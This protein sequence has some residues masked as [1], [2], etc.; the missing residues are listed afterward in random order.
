MHLKQTFLAIAVSLYFV[1]AGSC[2]FSQEQPDCISTLPDDLLCNILEYLPIRDALSACKT[3]S[4]AAI[5]IEEAPLIRFQNVWNSAPSHVFYQILNGIQQFSSATYNPSRLWLKQKLL[6]TLIVPPQRLF[7]DIT[8]R[9]AMKD[10]GFVTETSS[11]NGWDVSL[12]ASDGNSLSV[13]WELVYR[14]SLFGFGAG[15]FHQACD[16]E[17]KYVVVVRAEN[18]RI[19]V[20]YNEDGFQS[21]FSITPNLNGFI[22]SINEDGTCGAQFDRNGG[23]FG[24]F[25]NPRYGPV[26]GYF[27]LGILPERGSRSWLG[28]SYG[29][30]PE[31]NTKT[32]FGQEFFEASNYEVFKVVVTEN[33]SSEKDNE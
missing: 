20:A 26:I 6:Q 25:N 9:I 29:E 28:N 21:D 11:Q 10:R 30:R 27:D 13:T 33:A 8:K 14:A 23:E 24:I 22:V 19:A 1:Y 31:A 16:G 4:G 2:Q 32:L 15:E 17:G 5:A 12:T 18:G 3:I 7:A